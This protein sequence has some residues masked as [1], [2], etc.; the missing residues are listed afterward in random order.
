MN[1]DRYSVT[2]NN[3][4]QVKSNKGKVMIFK[5]IEEI[6]YVCYRKKYQPQ[7]II[8]FQEVQV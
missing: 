2:F 3:R 7:K 6:K 4:T 5:D 1:Q 8:T